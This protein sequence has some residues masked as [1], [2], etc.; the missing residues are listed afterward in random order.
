M[1]NTGDFFI[2]LTMSEEIDFMFLEQAVEENTI[3][4]LQTEMEEENVPEAAEEPGEETDEDEDEDVYHSRF[5]GMNRST[6]EIF[7]DIPTNDNKKSEPLPHDEVIAVTYEFSGFRFLFFTQVT[8]PTEY[9]L[10]PQVKT[11]ALKIVLPDKLLDANRRKF[12]RVTVPDKKNIKVYYLVLK[13]GAT[14][15]LDE[16]ADKSRYFK[17]V[18]I[19]IS[20][21]G[22]A[23]KSEKPVDLQP[24]E[25]MMIW[26][27]LE[28]KDKDYIEAK[29]V[30][31]NIRQYKY[32]GKETN[33]WGIEFVPTKDIKHKRAL[34][35]ISRYVMRNQR[36]VLSRTR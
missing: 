5:L 35:Q 19:D 1:I 32:K 25:E 34:N 31:R 30:V 20:Q 10:N 24:E 36:S 12:F 11:A 3:I 27:K 21:G 29:G 23:V 15:L 28:E 2:I 8:E 22:L 16:K 6:G 7:I 33:L 14:L 9:R 13:A 4:R 18:M 17:A 26:F